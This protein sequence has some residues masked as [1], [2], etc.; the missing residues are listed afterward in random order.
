M[1]SIFIIH[2]LRKFVQRSNSGEQELF[3]AQL[4]IA[5]AVDLTDLQKFIIMHTSDAPHM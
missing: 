1:Q 3:C 2:S 4:V 5:K